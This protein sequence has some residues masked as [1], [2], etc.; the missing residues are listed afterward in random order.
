MKKPRE[1]CH[2]EKIFEYKQLEARYTLKPNRRDELLDK[3]VYVE[4]E[5]DSVVFGCNRLRGRVTNKRDYVWEPNEPGVV[6]RVRFRRTSF[7]F[8]RDWENSFVD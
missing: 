7:D 5:T 4:Q 3:H 6:V 1:I 2:W 8:A